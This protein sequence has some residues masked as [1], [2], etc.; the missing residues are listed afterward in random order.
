VHALDAR[1]RGPGYAQR[2]ASARIPGYWRLPAAPLACLRTFLSRP[3]RLTTTI[4]L[5][6]P[7]RTPHLPP[8]VSLPHPGSRKKCPARTHR[9]RPARLAR[10]SPAS[11]TLL[12]TKRT[13]TLIAS[14]ARSKSGAT[15]FRQR[16]CW[17]CRARLAGHRST[18][19]CERCPPSWC[20]ATVTNSAS[21]TPFCAAAERLWTASTSV[22]NARLPASMLPCVSICC[23]SRA[24]SLSPPPSAAAVLIK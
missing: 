5:G 13:M 12:L 16:Q 20:A 17:P 24:L 9:P 19:L 4:L 1:P 15:P 18:R 21:V 11:S 8:S 22:G 6:A 14:L 2:G 23:D 7:Q 3:P 10:T